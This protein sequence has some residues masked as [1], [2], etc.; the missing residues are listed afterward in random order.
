MNDSALGP[1]VK[2]EDKFRKRELAKIHIGRQ[3]LGWDDEMY[4]SVLRKLTGS[5]SASL[6]NGGDRRR[7]LDYMK[8]NGFKDAPKNPRRA[9]TRPI[10]DGELQGKIRAL[11]LSLYHLGGVR[12][13]SEAA[14]SAYVKR[15]THS[16]GRPGVEALQFLRAETADE[17]IRPLRKWCERVGFFLPIAATVKVYDHQRRRAQMEEG[18]H[19]L[20]SKALLIHRLWELLIENGAMKHGIFASL[21]TWLRTKYKVAAPWFL[22]AEQ[23]DEAIEQL[24]RWLRR[25]RKEKGK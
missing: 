6:L 7:V 1:R 21:E 13:P 5:N 11:W 2:P 22:S 3:R 20:A 9:G 18:G 12:D 16:E 8:A 19:G 15:M 10:A 25:V 24:G 14:L 4:R 23:A 17:V